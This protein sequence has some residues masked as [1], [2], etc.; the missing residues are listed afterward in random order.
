MQVRRLLHGGDRPDAVPEVHGQLHLEDVEHPGRRARDVDGLGRPVPPR[1]HEDGREGRAARTGRLRSDQVR[2][3][4]ARQRHPLSG[5][6]QGR[7]ERGLERDGG[8]GPTV[9]RD[10]VVGI[11]DEHKQPYVLLASGEKH[12][13]ADYHTVFCSID[14]DDLWG[15]DTLP[16]TG[17]MM[18][19]LLIPGLAGAFPEGAESLHY[20]S[21]EFQTRVTEMKVITRHDSPDTLILIE[22]PVL[23][24]AAQCFPKNTIDYALENNLFTEKA[25]PQQSEQAFATYHCVRRARQEDPQP[26]LCRPPRRVQVLGNAG[27]GEFRLPEGAGISGG[28][29]D[30]VMDAAHPRVLASTTSHKREPLLPTL[31]V[32]S[33][34]RPARHRSEPAPHSRGRRDGRG[35]R[36]ASPRR[37]AFASGSCQ[38]DGA[39]SSRRPDSERDVRSVARQVRHRGPARRRSAPPVFRPLEARGLFARAPCETARR[40]LWRLSDLHPDMLFIFENHDGASL[41]PEVCR[42]ILR[43]RRPAEHPDELRPDQ[44]RARPA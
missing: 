44:L 11:R 13:F 20:S 28:V 43:S 38:A 36:R 10:R 16:Y 18:I 27:D 9:V 25:Y 3:S 12:Y 22:V 2:R 32:F 6:S 19:P 7:M 8:A 40:N 17:R 42:E 1:L 33:P 21:C 30:A 34:P 35:G 4:H 15:E 41:H 5:V 23:P 24:G 37:A 29:M 39:T 26:A 14:I 31:E